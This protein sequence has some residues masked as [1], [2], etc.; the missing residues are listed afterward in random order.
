M[1]RV[2]ARDASRPS[3]LTRAS[4]YRKETSM[5]VVLADLRGPN[6]GY[7]S[8]DTVVGGYGAR[9]VPFSR[10]TRILA[11]IKQRVHDPPS[12]QM[13]YLAAIAAREG[14]DVVWTQSET[15]D[16]DVAVVLSSLVDYRREAA[17]AEA[18][19]AR[20]VHVGV[21]G[22]AASKMPELFEA[23]ADFIIVGEPEAAFERLMRGERLTGRCVSE[24]IG[25]LDGLPLPRWDLVNAGMS[26]WSFSGRT[27]RPSGGGFPVLASRSCPEFCT[28][29]PH[30]VL[31]T[32]RAR[33]VRSILDELAW[34][35]SRQRN[36]YVIFRDPLFSQDRDRCLELADGIR[37]LGLQ[38]RF[39]CETRLDR[40]DPEVID[41][42]YDAGLRA[43]TFGVE[44]VSPAT[45]RKVG[46]R[47]IPP[48]HQRLVI[49]HCRRR[50]ITTVAFYVFG[51]LED[52]W[53]SI[54]ATIDY[55]IDLRSVFA[56][57]KLLTPYPGTP[58]WKRMQPLV[59]ESDWQ[60]FDGFTPTFKHPTVSAEQLQFLLGAA[61]V[62]FY[63][64]PSFLA[65]F[66]RW[67]RPP[68]QR[69]SRRLD[70]RVSNIQSR[71]E[72][73]IMSRPVTC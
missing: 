20:G 3:L 27:V 50:G 54:A 53:D 28:Y 4:R 68:V 17:W 19:Q 57:F 64:R 61:Y 21:V 72:I 56:Q 5:R 43:I 35:S 46:R 34:L 6:D 42:L 58:L 70:R 31:S 18:M 52:D 26:R 49:D 69:L 63:L 51:F 41:R 48:E 59:T 62:R 12:I 39:E 2:R 60:R 13:A 29:C 71:K 10:T 16:G 1:R 15:R 36:P 24:E 67:D 55:A 40:L 9:L 65:N 38:L 73:A 23:H 37:R 44:A 66:L 14:H 22:L 32:Y 7:L 33:S 45:L 25:D 30:R 47:P 8:K 11:R